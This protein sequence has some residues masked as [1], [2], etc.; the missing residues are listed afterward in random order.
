MLHDNLL[1]LTLVTFTLHCW[2]D[3]GKQIIVD[4]TYLLYI[5]QNV[6]QIY[7]F[8][9]SIVQNFFWLLRVLLYLRCSADLVAILSQFHALLKS[10]GLWRGTKDQMGGKR[11][12]IL[13]STLDIGPECRKGN[14]TKLCQEFLKSTKFWARCVF[15]VCLYH[16]FNC[17]T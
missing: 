5:F 10:I 14:I 7:L 11:V 13:K 1:R 4:F 8:L 3:G 12:R 6:F 2:T 15:Q 9:F 16:I 17:T